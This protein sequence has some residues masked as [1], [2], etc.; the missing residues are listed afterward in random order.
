MSKKK[1]AIPSYLYYKDAFSNFSRITSDLLQS[2]PFQNL[3]HAARAFYIVLV[4]HKNT[5]LQRECLFNSLKD[6]HKLTGN[7]VTDFDLSVEAG[8]YS[9]QKY[10]SPY[11][12]IPEKQLKEYGYS[13]QY[14]NKLKKE[15]INNG[16]IEI[17][18]NAKSINNDSYC[19]CSSKRVTI[20]KF[21]N[22]WKR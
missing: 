21:V 20:Y 5:A 10:D 18:A 11:F 12:V 17:F 3:S 6:Y 22:Y 1:K 19:R 14:A 9:R 13:S 4:T 7:E 15:L 8:T 16:F 2:E